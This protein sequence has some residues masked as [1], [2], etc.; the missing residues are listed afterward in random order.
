MRGRRRRTSAILALPVL[1]TRRA[2]GRIARRAL[3][4]RVAH[5]LLLLG[6]IAWG[7]RVD[8]R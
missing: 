5:L 3:L 4:G 2:L 6:R 8:G 7:A 1:P